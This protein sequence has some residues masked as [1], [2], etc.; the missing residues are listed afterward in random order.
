MRRFFVALAAL[1]GLALPTRAAEPEKDYSTLTNLLQ[2]LQQSYSE[3]LASDSLRADRN[4]RREQLADMIKA[5]DEMTLNLYS[6]EA[7]FAFDQAFALEYMSGI[8][9][10]FDEQAR[11]SSKDMVESR[12]GLRRYTMLEESLRDMYLK[13]PVDSLLQADSLLGPVPVLP[14]EE[15]DPEKQA[16]LD[17]CLNYTHALADIYRVSVGMALQ[18]SLYIAE[19]VRRIQQAYDYVQASY[20][21]SQKTRF[22]GGNVNAI[23][24]IRNWDSV[25]QEITEDLVKRYASD[26]L[27][28]ENIEDELNTHSWRGDFILGYGM[29]ALFMLLI[30]FLI[31]G[32]ISLFLF[33]R[34]R[35]EKVRA[36][37]PILSSILAVFLFALGM[38]LIRSDRS[39]PYWRMAYLLLS[40]FSWLTLAIFVSL[41][42]RIRGDQAKASRNIY[43]PTLLLA[44]LC[45]LMRAV[46]LPASIV[47]LIFPP[48]LLLFIIWQ[49]SAN[50]RY[51]AQVSGA[52]RR[53]MWVSVGVMSIVCVLSLVGYSMIGVLIMTFWTFLLALLHTI[54]T[55]YYLMRRYYDDKVLR[56]KARY[57]QE[58]PLLPLDDKDAFIEVTWFYDLLQKVVVPV[59]ILMAFPL[60]ILL[61]AQAYQLSQAGMSLLNEPL[62]RHAEEAQPLLDIAVDG[63]NNVTAAVSAAQS[64]LDYL[65]IHNIILVAALFFI[66]RYLIYL[67]KALYRV[68]KLR[69]LIEKK[70][71][72]QEDMD[73]LKESDVN[74]SLTN[75]L[76]SL[77]GWFVYLVI[78][79]T[80]LHIPTSAI[81]AI[82]TGLAAGVGFALKDL[83]NN[84]FY[85][86]QLMAGRIRIGDKISCD[87][88]R[89]IVKRVSYQTTQVLDE[90]GSLIAFTNTDLFTK[91]FRNLNS[92]KNYEFIKMPVGVRYGTDVAYAREVI[93]EALKP[94]MVKDKYGRDIV[95]PSFPVDV[96]FDSFG[97]SSVN[98]VVA[99][100]TTVETHYTFPARAKE[101]IYNAFH[102]KGI[103]IPFPQRDV[104]IKTVPEK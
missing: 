10:S 19:T 87:G 71:G 39:N 15:V 98:L 66:F 8:H 57:H 53:Y 42:I 3:V 5:A 2:E 23:Q 64:G 72:S 101:A 48:V 21:D 95:D 50:I 40:Q 37:T 7:D 102:E 17:S 11:L 74:L 78:A 41:L 85:G 18:D 51:R 80:I 93:L 55:L 44:F 25:K 12:A 90:D 77:G 81:T 103:D 49:T 34:S 82:S 26:Q 46:F 30:A 63:E 60:S 79:F 6:R 13:H 94:L 96:R 1:A 28:D 16:L 61:T 88:V 31:A 56:R 52:D 36:F 29:I 54:T 4:Q 45:I 83:I 75:T 70:K 104:Y 97:D 100:Y 69:R 68:F 62:F 91:Q 76:I 14:H 24:I 92:G 73:P 99:L 43:I 47:P 20:A 35:K 27:T 65:T 38:L 9:A 89:G 59:M 84:F 22:I 33:K 67:V 86:I 32:V 58:N